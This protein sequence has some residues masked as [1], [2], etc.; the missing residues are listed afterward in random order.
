M[1]T[2]RFLRD[3]DD[4]TKYGQGLEMAYLDA[5]NAIVSISNQLRYESG[6]LDL[7]DCENPFTNLLCE[8]RATTFTMGLVIHDC[9]DRRKRLADVARGLSN[10]VFDE[11]SSQKQLGPQ[12]KSR[13]L[14]ADPSGG[15]HADVSLG[16]RDEPGQGS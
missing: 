5:F 12:G 13:D 10:V 9:A 15:R 4:E 16:E 7:L 2:V 3:I 1:E 11:E 14:R 8:I 6:E